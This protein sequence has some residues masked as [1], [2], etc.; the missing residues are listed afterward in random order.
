MAESHDNEEVFFVDPDFRGIIP[1]DNFHTPRKLRRQIRKQFFKI[2]CDTAFE[3]VL[4]SCAETRE[5]SQGTWIN[6][7]IK[8]LYIELF[9]RGSCHSVEIWLNEE[10]VGGLYGVALGGAFFGESMFSR[11]T[12][13]SKVALVYLVAKLR[14]DGFL[15]LDSQFL[16]DHLAQFGAIQINR[17]DYHQK[18]NTALNE[19]AS[20]KPYS[21]DFN[22]LTEFLQSKTQMS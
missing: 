3:A 2:T 8:R 6:R 10:L 9:E 16:T 5:N 4:N 18:L 7:E 17:N 21:N 19:T 14:S 12:N 11:I 1:L 13:A 15:L 20:F 22:L